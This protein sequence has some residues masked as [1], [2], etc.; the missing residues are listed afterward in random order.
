MSFFCLEC[1]RENP[2]L[3][4]FCISCGA[5]NTRTKRQ[6]I[7]HGNGVSSKLNNAEKS[8]IDEAGVSDV[9][10]LYR[11][12]GHDSAHYVS[13]AQSTIV[14][15]GGLVGSNVTDIEAR[16]LA[17][18]KNLMLGLTHQKKDTAVEASVF[19]DSERNNFSRRLVGWLVQINEP[20]AGR[21]FRFFRGL[22]RIGRDPNNDIRIADFSISA[23]HAVMWCDCKSVTITDLKSQ[24]G[25]LL[26]GQPVLHSVQL[27]EG[28]ELIFGDVCM[29]LSLFKWR[30][31]NG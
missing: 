18:Q 22:N 21:D 25:T 10:A 15:S 12:R 8:T 1:F 3:A 13:N 24:N 19:V 27:I 26:N 11:L 16:R 30:E 6:N 31:D 9:S 20:N 28:D 7:I 17:P 5:E 2:N 29:Q 4:I 23:D 14:R